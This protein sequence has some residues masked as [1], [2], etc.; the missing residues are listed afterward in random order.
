LIQH[1]VKCKRT[2]YGRYDGGGEGRGKRRLGGEGK[3]SESSE[4][5]CFTQKLF[6][7]KSEILI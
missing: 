7:F 6:E 1:F 2:K 5:D 4:K 3:N